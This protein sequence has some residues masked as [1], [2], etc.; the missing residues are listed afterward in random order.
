V[1]VEVLVVVLEY[2]AA[3]ALERAA[4]SQHSGVGPSVVEDIYYIDVVSSGLYHYYN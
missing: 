1:V 2:S 4:A 3:V